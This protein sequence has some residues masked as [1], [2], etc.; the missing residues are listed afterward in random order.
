MESWLLKEG[1]HEAFVEVYHALHVKLFR[2]FLKKVSL[3]DVAK[4]LTQQ[5]F[6]RL[7]QYRESLSLDHPLEKQVFIIARS[8]LINHLKKEATQK[9]AYA[10][11]GRT[12]VLEVPPEKEMQFEQTD[13]VSAAIDTLPPVRKRIMILKTFHGYSNNEIAQQLEISVKTVED[14]VTK[15]FRQLRHKFFYL[16]QG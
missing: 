11:L 10:A 5:C 2:W 16:R 15:S 9:Q 4:E 14:H 13:A 12:I 7:W 6:I 3:H 1:N 8:L